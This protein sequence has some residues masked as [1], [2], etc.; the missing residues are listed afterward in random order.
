MVSDLENENPNIYK[1]T[2]ARI[3]TEDERND[4]VIDP[5]DEREIFGKNQRKYGKF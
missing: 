5:I 4:D 3:I 1:K 2:E